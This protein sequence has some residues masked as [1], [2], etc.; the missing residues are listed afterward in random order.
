MENLVAGKSRHQSRFASANWRPAEFL[1][2]VVH[3]GVI[4]DQRGWLTGKKL[5]RYPA[6]NPKG[7]PGAEHGIEQPRHFLILNFRRVIDRVKDADAGD[8]PSQPIHRQYCR[9]PK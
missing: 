9:P 3:L 7:D 2:E 1:C 4:R 5:E 6:G 8:Y